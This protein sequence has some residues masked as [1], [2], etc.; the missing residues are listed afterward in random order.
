M[1]IWPRCVLLDDVPRWISGGHQML[2]LLQC[3]D[4]HRQRR[5]GIQ[6]KPG[7]DVLCSGFGP[8]PFS[9]CVLVS[10]QGQSPVKLMLGILRW[11]MQGGI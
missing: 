4:C 10:H 1:W 11:S 6:S 2:S 5:R 7:S 9:L 8:F 3:S